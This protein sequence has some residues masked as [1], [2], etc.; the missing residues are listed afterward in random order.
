MKPAT[1]LIRA[2]EIHHRGF[3]PVDSALD[4]CE[5]REMFWIFQ[6]ES[7]RGAGIE[8]DIEN[9]VDLL[10]AVIRELAEEAFAR[11]R[12]VPGIRTF[13]LEG[14]DD[15]QFDLG[16]LQNFDRAVRLLLHKQCP[17]HPPPTL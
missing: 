7:V 2:F 16:I 3:A 8:P 5:C 17:R 1:V 13:V 9:V 11:T 12:L 14:F 4:A 6:N 15:P 10:P